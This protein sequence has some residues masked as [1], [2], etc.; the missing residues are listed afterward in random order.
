MKTT[1]SRIIFFAIAITYNLLLGLYLKDFLVLSETLT[2]FYLLSVLPTEGRLTGSLYTSYTY[3]EAGHL[4]E[5][6]SHSY[7]YEEGMLVA[8]DDQRLMTTKQEDGILTVEYGVYVLTYTSVALDTEDADMARYRWNQMRF[9]YNR[10]SY[11]GFVDSV[12]VHNPIYDFDTALL[13]PDDIF[14]VT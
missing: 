12:C 10:S 14:A 4:M 5:D 3:D 7:H 1:K 8:I 11:F 6:G 13:L 9:G 2:A